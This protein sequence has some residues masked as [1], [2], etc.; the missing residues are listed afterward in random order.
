[1]NRQPIC[2]IAGLAYEL[3]EPALVAEL[4]GLAANHGLRSL[5]LDGGLER[6]AASALPPSQLARRSMKRTLETAGVSPDAVDMVLYASN[7]FD[8]PEVSRG[9][10]LQSVLRELDLLAA[11]PIGVTMAGCSNAMAAL[12][13]AADA[14]LRGANAVLVVTVDRAA[15][16]EDRVLPQA[17][18]VLSD[19]AA[20][21]LVGPAGRGDHDVLGLSFRCA[22]HLANMDMSEPAFLIGTVNSSREVIREVLDA[23]GLGPEDIVLA[24]GNN[25]RRPLVST[26]LSYGGLDGVALY[27]DNLARFAHC[28][29]ADTFINLTDAAREARLPRGG[30]ALLL[31]NTFFLWGACVVRR[32]E[33][34][35]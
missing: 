26:L 30:A 31:A 11:L 17:V 33:Q 15:P 25:F 28:Q 20:S 6:Y 27:E 8:N 3:G 7:S 14:V 35:R 5:L 12:R 4:P 16:E 29:S 34:E 18:A 21:F 32:S 2:S 23:C 9:L 1:M 10:D 22:P 24:T 19:G 13:I